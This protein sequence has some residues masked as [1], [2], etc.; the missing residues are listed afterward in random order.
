M[1]FNLLFAFYILHRL[2]VHV[3]LFILHIAILKKKKSGITHVCVCGGGRGGVCIFFFFF[4]LRILQ[5]LLLLNYQDS[6]DGELDAILKELCALGSQFDQEL[7]DDV[8]RPVTTSNQP[9]SAHGIIDNQ[10]K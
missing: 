3:L 10:C 9:S 8:G 6:Q 4:T 2:Y 1:P 7:K 5:F